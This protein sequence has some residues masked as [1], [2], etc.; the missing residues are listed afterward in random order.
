MALR[1]LYQGSA[2]DFAEVIA[3]GHLVE[4]MRR[5][6]VAM[7]GARPRE[8]ESA[9][10]G[11]SIPTVVHLLMGVVLRDVQVLVEWAHCGSTA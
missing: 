11:G 3:Q 5:R 7:H 10:W 6:L 8:S 9:S 1:C 4:E 2:G